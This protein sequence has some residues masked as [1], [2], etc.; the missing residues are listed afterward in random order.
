MKKLIQS[1]LTGITGTIS[2]KRVVLFIVVFVFVA[3]ILVNLHNPTKMLSPT[4]Q[5]QLYQ[6]LV[7]NM[8]LVFGETAIPS[9]KGTLG[10]LGFKDPEQPAN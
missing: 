1:M 3:V 10:K 7:I 8:G 5:D 2:S 4:L 9:I 6:F